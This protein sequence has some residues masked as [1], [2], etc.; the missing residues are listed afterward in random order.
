MKNQQEYNDLLQP[1]LLNSVEGLVLMSKMIIGSYLLGQN[2]SIKTGQGQVFRQYRSYQP[3]DDLRLLDWKMYA[4]S[5][6]Y[7][8]KESEIETNIT[9]KFVIDASASMLHEDQPKGS[10]VSIKKIDFARLLAATL[11]HLALE[12]GDAIGLFAINENQ[13]VQLAPRQHRQH[14]H[15][16]VY[17]LLQI[18]PGGKFP[19]VNDSPLLYHNQGGNKE[20]IVFISDMYQHSHEIYKTLEQLSALRNEVLFFH[21]MGNN[22]LELNYKG[23]VTLEDLETGQ[24][25][26]VDSQK[27]RKQYKE[28][29]AQHLN[30]IKTQM[31]DLEISYDLFSMGE[32]LDRA[33]NDFLVKRRF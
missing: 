2:Q 11:A 8:V 21:L 31:L 5:G 23:T 32:P 16:F 3:G 26:Q 24:R 6:R 33:L 25:V 20:M 19:A 14:L 17:E 12:Q 30:K 28:Q 18:K 9:V 7:F 22:E 29:L 27:V 13:L 10:K 4:R 1:E 15:R